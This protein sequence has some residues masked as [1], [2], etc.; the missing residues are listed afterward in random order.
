MLSTPH[1]QRTSPWTCLTAV[2]AARRAKEAPVKRLP[3]N[4]LALDSTHTAKWP[5]GRLTSHGFWKQRNLDFL[6]VAKLLPPPPPPPLFL[7]ISLSL[8]LSPVSH[9][10]GAREIAHTR[11]ADDG[12]TRTCE[13][14]S[15]QH[16][17][18]LSTLMIAEA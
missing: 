1:R 5:D 6:S 11:P 16:T 4:R 13:P 14:F 8:S 7:S 17:L 12:G 9:S 3:R 2:Y 18:S 10:H 15:R